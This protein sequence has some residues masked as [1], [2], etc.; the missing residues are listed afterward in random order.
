MY[1]NIEL[2][3]RKFVA[4]EFIFGID[5]RFQ[6]ANYCLKYG[7]KKLF[8]VTDKGLLNTKWIKDIENQLKENNI[9]YVIFSDISPNP[10][11]YEV[12]Q[13][14][15]EYLK[16]KCNIILSVGGGSVLDCAKGDRKSVV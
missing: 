16:N 11:D 6:T 1:N 12:M 14:S 15:E 10:R 9:E 7:V 2:Q 13:G 5:A 8:F 3:L 4:P